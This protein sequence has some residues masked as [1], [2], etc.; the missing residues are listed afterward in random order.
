MIDNHRL[1]PA[2]GLGALTRVIDDE[3]IDVRQRPDQGIRPA[4][5][6]QAHALAWQPFKVAVLANMDQRVSGKTM[7]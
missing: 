6:G 4:T 3:R 5:G 1:G 7:A 2:L